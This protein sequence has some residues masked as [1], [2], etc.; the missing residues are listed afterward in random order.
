MQS[1]TYL[2]ASI[3]NGELIRWSVMPLNVYI[4]P[5]QFY[6]KK[7]QDSIYQRMVVRALDEWVSASNGKFKYNLT[8]Y[9]NSQI[10]LTWK[11]VERTA[12]GHCYTEYTPNGNQLFSAEV[13]IGLSDGVIHQKYMAEDEVYHTILHEIGH[14]LGLGHSPYKS[15]IMYTPHQY[16]VVSLSTNDKHSIQWLY[17]LPTN[18]NVKE[19]CSKHGLSNSLNLDEAIKKQATDT[20]SQ[21]LT[22]AAP[23]N[24]QRD[25]ITEA[26]NIGDIKRYNMLINQSVNLSNDV[27]KYLEDLRRK[28]N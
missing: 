21:R 9:H 15:D 16:G 28:N 3:R 10:N 7:G 24:P 17:T 12:L 25:L 1:K 5:M 23:I 22:Q 6:S 11:R 4:A 27:K 13:S 14:A 18:M 26:A 2:N 20:T 19:Y 8:D